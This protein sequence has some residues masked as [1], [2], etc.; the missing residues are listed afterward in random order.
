MQDESSVM[1][2]TRLS[3]MRPMQL[4]PPVVAACLCC[5]FAAIAA[6]AQSHPNVVLFI[7]DDQ[8]FDAMDAA[9]NPAIQTVAMDRL[10]K[11]GVYYPQATIHVPQCSPSRA[12]LLT[13]LAPHQSGWFSNQAQSSA[14]IETGKFKTLPM[15]PALLRDQAGYRTV[16]VGKWHIQIDPWDCGFAEVRTWL[17][18]GSAAYV[19]AN[20]SHGNSRQR[21]PSEGF[22]NQIF[23]DDAVAFL[24]S[25]AAKEKPFFLW[26]ALTAPHG[27]I[28]PNPPEV[29]KLYAGKSGPD[30]IPPGFPKDRAE[31]GD[32][33]HY[34]EA[35]TMADRQLANVLDALDKQKLADD[36]IVIFLGDNGFMMGERDVP[37][38]KGPRKHYVGKVFPYE[39]SVR[40]PLMIRGPGFK[41]AKDDKPVSSLDLP[42][43]ILAAAGLKPPATWSGRDLHD[44]SKI[45]EAFCEFADNE[46]DKFGDIAY[47]LVRTPRYKLIVYEQKTRPDELYDVSADPLEQKNLAADPSMKTVRDDL[48]SRLRDWMR[49]TG[50]P[51]LKWRE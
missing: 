38:F 14:R 23:G 36:T 45:A 11:E 41:A 26:L 31:V 46:S 4:R 48:L 40:V 10:I 43:T 37:Q 51:A 44:T 20:L 24:N 2:L 39:A 8:R 17:P 18:A 35:C 28:K 15:L 50:D 19:D 1:F 22:I 33:R 42:T 29:E 7:T 49:R 16:F 34:Y 25:D 21:T 9:G 30:L 5:F 12:T 32:W 27:P 13:G 3:L 6:A 47:R